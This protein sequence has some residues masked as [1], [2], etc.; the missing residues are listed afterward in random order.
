MGGPG[1][2]QWGTFNFQPVQKSHSGGTHPVNA[3]CV[4]A[5]A[6]PQSQGLLNVGEKLACGVT[7]NPHHYQESDSW[8]GS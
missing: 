4:V 3:T 8:D 6:H 1:Q 7:V 2:P 5:R